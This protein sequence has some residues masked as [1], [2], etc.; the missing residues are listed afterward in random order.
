MYFFILCWTATEGQAH[1]RELKIYFTICSD[2]RGFLLALAHGVKGWLC[3]GGIT[4][5]LQPRA[6]FFM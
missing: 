5:G 6:F 4:S 1:K 2:R 3:F